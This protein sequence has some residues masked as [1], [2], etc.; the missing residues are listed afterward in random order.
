MTVSA[1][2]FQAKGTIR[3]DQP[4]YS[5]SKLLSYAKYP[6]ESQKRLLAWS[7]E[8]IEP[9]ITPALQ[10]SV[11]WRPNLTWNYSPFEPSLNISSNEKKTVRF[12][13]EPVGVHAGTIRDPF[14]QTPVFDLLQ[15]LQEQCT[16][17]DLTLFNHFYREFEIPITADAI[18]NLA[19]QKQPISSSYFCAFDFAGDEVSS[20]DTKVYF[21]LDQLVLLTGNDAMDLIQYSVSRFRLDLWRGLQFRNRARPQ[22]SRVQYVCKQQR[23]RDACCGLQGA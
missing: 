3:P 15:S 10:H 1:E 6:E 2:E 9:A 23:C 8:H 7:Q 14:N 17:L 4:I 11:P 5:L 21:L 13:I 19:L 20:I 12:G 18:Q 22:V 16:Q